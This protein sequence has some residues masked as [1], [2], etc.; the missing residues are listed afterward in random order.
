MKLTKKVKKFKSWH[1]TGDAL[2]FEKKYGKH[3]H[4]SPTVKKQIKEYL[5]RHRRRR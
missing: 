3:E 5:A 1:F 4:F 2:A